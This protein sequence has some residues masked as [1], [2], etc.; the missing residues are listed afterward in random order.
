MES[1]K[2]YTIV[3]CRFEGK[4]TQKT[5]ATN[6]YISYRVTEG[7]VEDEFGAEH[8][9]K[10]KVFVYDT[11]CAEALNAMHYSDTFD[12]QHGCF[13]NESEALEALKEYESWCIR[14]GE[15]FDIMES[16]AMYMDNENPENCEYIAFAPLTEDSKTEF[17]I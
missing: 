9:M 5:P 15:E 14:S 1:D 13:E 12:E 4:L 16:Y 3:T 2:Y 7:Y 11:G 10:Q 17:A 8:P 6:P